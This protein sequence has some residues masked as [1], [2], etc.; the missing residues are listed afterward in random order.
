[1]RRVTVT[2]LVARRWVKVKITLSARSRKALLKALAKKQRL[3]LMLSGIAT[4]AGLKSGTARV[5]IRL[6]V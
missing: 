3:T 6:M 1:V 4:V 5:I 2:R